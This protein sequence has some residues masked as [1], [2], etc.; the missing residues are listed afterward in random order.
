MHTLSLYP[1]NQNPMNGRTL[2]RTLP[3][4]PEPVWCDKYSEKQ[5]REYAM[6][7]LRTAAQEVLEACAYTDW[8]EAGNTLADDLVPRAS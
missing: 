2:M 3:P 1:L 4:L 5:L 6:Q 7:V 8:E